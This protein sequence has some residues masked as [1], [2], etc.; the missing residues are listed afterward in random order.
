[1]KH[2]HI[3]TD[4][5]CLGNP[6]PGGYGAVIEYGEHHKEM[7]AGYQLTTNNRM[8]M[9]A[10]IKALEALKQPCKVTLTSDSQY[11]KQGIQSWIHNWKRNGWRTSN[12]KQVKNADLWQALDSVAQRHEIQWEWVKGHAGHPQNE[13]CDELARQ[14]ASGSKLHQDT[15]YQAD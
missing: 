3:Y 8:E 14:A 5:S 10:A 13:R 6:G 11:L 15:G 2:V 1:M 4:G 7:A 9:L 12:R